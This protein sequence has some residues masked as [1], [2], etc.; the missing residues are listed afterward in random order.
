MPLLFSPIARRLLAL[1]QARALDAWQALS[2]RFLDA[3]AAELDGRGD[4][5]TTLRWQLLAART[6]FYIQRCVTALAALRGRG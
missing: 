1:W 3:W 5:T 2:R 6:R 4:P